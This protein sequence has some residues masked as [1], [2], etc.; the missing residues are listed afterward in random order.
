MNKVLYNITISIDA[1]VEKD[2]L[3]WMQ[4][5]HIPDVMQT[6][7]FSENRICRVQDDQEEGGL[8][9]AV[10]YICNSMADFEDYQKNYAPELQA[11]HTTRYQGKFAA[12]RTILEII[13][14][15]PQPSIPI[16]AN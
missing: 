13:H 14:E 9:Y 15:Y 8:T 10:Q 2:W 3:K 6:G 16:S 5:V 7:F 12:F 4:E 11:E 1:S